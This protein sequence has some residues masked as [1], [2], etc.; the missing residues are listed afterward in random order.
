MTRMMNKKT[1]IALR[2]LRLDE[3]L[4]PQLRRLRAVTWTLTSLMVAI[5]LFMFV[6]FT[7]FRQPLIGLVV[8]LVAAGPLAYLAWREE[9]VVR[10]AAE[11]Y[12]KERDARASG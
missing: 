11:A 1:A 9:G 5:G 2:R 4:E 12:Q 7:A 3:P 10:R 6:L 8:A